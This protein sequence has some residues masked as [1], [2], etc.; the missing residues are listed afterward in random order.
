MASP[1]HAAKTTTF[2]LLCLLF[3]GSH[4]QLSA[5]AAFRGRMAELAAVQGA[6]PELERALLAEIEDILEARKHSLLDSLTR[7]FKSN[8]RHFVSMVPSRQ[9][10]E[11]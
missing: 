3:A 8:R 4:V 6:S 9:R 10:F 5:A 2:G 11:V 7:T 1:A